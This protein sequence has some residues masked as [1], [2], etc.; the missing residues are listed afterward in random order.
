MNTKRRAASLLLGVL[1]AACRSAPVPITTPVPTVTLASPT[2]SPAPTPSTSA[3]ALLGTWIR[4]DDMSQRWSF[5]AVPLLDG[6]VLVVGNGS[7]GEG[8][9]YGQ[10]GS[11][12]ADL[13]DPATGRWTP[14]ESLNAPRDGF[15]AVRLLDGSVLVTGGVDRNGVAFS[16][17]KL[18]DPATGHWS[19]SGLLNQARWGA[20]GALL[21]DG[22]VLVAG[23]WFFSAT[24]SRTLASAELYDPATGRWTTTGSLHRPRE[25]AA[26]Y[27]LPDGRVLVIGGWDA[28]GASEEHTAELYDPGTGKWTVI[29]QVPS[30]HVAPVVLDDG[31]LLFIG[32]TDDTA[33]ERVRP[34]ATVV[35]FDVASGLSTHL[36]PMPTPRTAGIAVRLADG[37]VLVAGGTDQV[38]SKVASPEHAK[39]LTTSALVY[40][41]AGDAWS[42]LP[43]I[44]YA[45]YGARAVLLADGSAVVLGGTLPQA[46]VSTGGGNCVGESVA[47]AARFIPTAAPKPTPVP[48]PPKPTGATFREDVECLD[49]ECNEARTTQTVTWRTPRTK[50][51]TIR[52]YGVTECLAAPAHAKPGASGPCLVTHTP[53]PASV[54]TLL[55]KAPASAGKVSWS[56]TQGEGCETSRFGSDPDGPPYV[57]VVLAAYNAS[58]QSIFTIAEPGSWSEPL[59]G[60]MPC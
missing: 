34:L 17:T 24:S 32:G 35:R 13:L 30:P 3:A 41:A 10:E 5:A 57:A 42:A 2:A 14:A 20:A 15:V 59:P 37:R 47:S 31:S 19:N 4:M 36:T 39:M 53:L 29:A 52:V 6:R 16:S 11:E 22:R 38:W 12:R 21:P 55:A 7:C 48:V 25:G 46:S 40:D 58:G 26:P 56:W 23:G 54:R 33:A 49:A 43:E 45:A 9:P 18:F 50:G 44:P 8:G 27:A 28:N 1:L 51:V 60:S